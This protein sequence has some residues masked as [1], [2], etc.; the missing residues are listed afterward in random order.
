MI[1][2]RVHGFRTEAAAAKAAAMATVPTAMATASMNAAA[3]RLDFLG[4]QGKAQH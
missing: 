3:S 2:A 1:T 4:N